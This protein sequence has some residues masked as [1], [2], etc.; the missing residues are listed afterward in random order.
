M[1]HVLWIV[2]VMSPCLIFDGVL[3]ARESLFKKVSHCN[4]INE[5]KIK[6]WRESQ[7]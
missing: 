3:L 6:C 1:M 4:R 7:D 2:R 5:K